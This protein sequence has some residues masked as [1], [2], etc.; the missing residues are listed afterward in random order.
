MAEKNNEKKQNVTRIDKTRLP[1]NTS[2][3]NPFLANSGNQ[4]KP[5]PKPNNEPKKPN[6]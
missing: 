1:T 6:K 5:K 4:D 2:E 3:S